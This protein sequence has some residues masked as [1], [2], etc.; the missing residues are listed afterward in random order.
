MKAREEKATRK[1]GKSTDGSTVHGFDIANIVVYSTLL[2]KKNI[3]LFWFFKKI[4]LHFFCL[5]RF[6]TRKSNAQNIDWPNRINEV[7]FR[8]KHFQIFRRKKI[9]VLRRNP[10]KIFQLLYENRNHDKTFFLSVIHSVDWVNQ[11]KLV[12][13]IPSVSVFFLKQIHTLDCRN[14]FK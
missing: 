10:K 13:S 6:N 11:I 12:H 9:W 2:S 4:L 1:Q 3:I 8:L 7:W 5:I 14:Q